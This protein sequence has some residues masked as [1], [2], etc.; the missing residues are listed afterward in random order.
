MIPTIANTN[1]LNSIVPISRFNKGEASKIFEEVNISGTK[2]VVKNNVPSCVLISP[3]QY[4]KMM[5]MLEDYALLIEAE[6]RV[7]KA[8]NNSDFTQEEIFK[9]LGITTEDLEDIEVEID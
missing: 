1:I 9:D 2:I 4:E 3:E 6:E 5:D 7:K 8:N